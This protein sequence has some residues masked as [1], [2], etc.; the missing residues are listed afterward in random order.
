LKPPLERITNNRMVRC[1]RWQEIEAGELA[2]EAEEALSIRNDLDD[3]AS[4]IMKVEEI[5]KH[6]PVQASLLDKIQ[7]KEAPPIRAVD[8]INL[9]I[10][11]GQTL[12]LVGESGSGKTTLSR[13]II[14]LQE[15]TG[16][17]IE[18]LGMDIRNAVRERSPDVLAKIQMVFQNPQNSLNPYL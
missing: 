13:V 3:S 6:F 16:G 15:R 4:I 12:G 5:S 9:S 18:L 10:R 8:G 7:G 1:H 17:K 11:Q 2:Y 14:G